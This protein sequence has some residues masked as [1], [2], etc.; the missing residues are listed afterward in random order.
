M[1][2]F[3][4]PSFLDQLSLGSIFGSSV[5]PECQPTNFGLISQANNF[6]YWH[7]DFSAT[8]VFYHLLKGKK[9][10]YI[11]PRTDN[12]VRLLKKDFTTKFGRA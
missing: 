4:A 9:E 11:C 1:A 8:S 7:V 2:L 5:P 10:F 6:T 12:N 3:Q